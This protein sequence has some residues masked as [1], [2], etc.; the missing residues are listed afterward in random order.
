LRV[1]EQ[2]TCL[3]LQ[4]HDDDD[5]DDDDDETLTQKYTQKREDFSVLIRHKSS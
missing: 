1:K 2:E 5:D 4:E 3:A